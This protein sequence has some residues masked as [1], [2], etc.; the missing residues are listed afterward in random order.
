MNT[1]LRFSLISMVATLVG[2]LFA[3]AAEP[4]GYERKA[5]WSETMLS[6]RAALMAVG[7]TNAATDLRTQ[8]QRR[9]EKDFPVPSRAM[10]T[11]LSGRG[12]KPL[13]WFESDASSDLEREMIDLALREC[14]PDGSRLR[15]SLEQLTQSKVPASNPQWLSLYEKAVQLR[16]RPNQLRSINLPA[17]R[18]AVEDLKAGFGE[19]YPRG[20]E[21]LAQIGTMEREMAELEA[22]T[23]DGKTADPQRATALVAA[24]SKLQREA[25]L[26]NPLLDF[27]RVLVV[28]RQTGEVEEPAGKDG[29]KKKVSRQLGLPQ[30]WQGNCALP[31]GG[32][33][34]QVAVL[35]PVNG[36]GRLTPLFTPEAGRFVGDVDLHFDADR[37]LLS[38]PDS[39]RRWQ[40]WELNIDGTAL[41][42][43][44]PTN[45]TDVDWYD[46]CYL[47]DGRI[48]FAGTAVFQGVPCV[49]GGNKV[50]NMYLLAPRTG[51][52]R[53]V[54]FDQEHNWCP[55]VL[56]NGR[57]LYA[58]WEYTDSPHYFTRLL[59]HM[60]PDGTEQMEFYG[61]NSY[62]PNSIFYARPIPGHPT[63]VV[64][65]ISGHHGV[66]RMGEL[67]VFDPSKGRH[68]NGGAV[69]R[70]PGHGQTVQP[71]VRDG[72][73]EN[74]WP[75]FLHPYP[76]SDKHFLVSAKPNAQS[77]WGIYLVD[78]FDNMVLLH[79]E[80][81]FALLEPVPVRKTPAPPAIQDRVNLARTDATVYL[82]DIYS[83][84][85]LAGVP[86]GAVKSLRIFEYHFAYAGMGGHIN[87]GIDGPWDVHRIIG[88][89]PVNEDGSV[90]FRVPANR[91][92]AVQPLD[93]EGKALQVMRSWFTAMPGENVSC[94]GC[95]EKQNSAPALRPTLASI[96]E[97]VPIQPWHGP[98]RGFSF[99]REVQPVLDQYCVGCHDGKAR[100]DGRTIPDFSAEQPNF[101]LAKKNPRKK[102]G[103]FEF[104]A[105]YVALHPYVRRPGPESDY[106]LQNPGEWHADTSELVQLLQK[107]HHGVKLS[108][109]AWD[110]LITWIDLNVPDHGTW[111]EHRKIPGN[112]AERRRETLARYANRTDDPETYPMPAPERK[113]A[114][115]PTTSET[116]APRP[117][118]IVL[119][120]GWPF[121]GSE[122]RQRQTAA[123]FA[124]QL[125][126][127]ISD[128]LTMELTLIPAGE[129]V[130]GRADGFADEQPQ[131]IVRI[132]K[133]FY[134][135]SFEVSNEEFGAFDPTHDSRVISV[136]NK[137]ISSPGE[138]ANRPRGAVIRVSWQ[139]AMAFCQWLSA[140]TGRRFTLPNEAQWEYACRAG[141]DTAWS[142]GGDAAIF[143]KFANLADE[144]LE[145]LCRGDSPKWIP[146]I[147]NLNDG[148]V[149]VDNVGRYQANA[150]GLKDM[151]GNVAEW[152]LSTCAPYPF[153]K[154]GRDDGSSTGR[155][156][157]R[158]GSFYDRP[159][160]ATSSFRLSY[161][162]WQR[163]FNVGF[164][165]ACE[166]EARV[167]TK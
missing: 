104:D 113:V 61:S 49:G 16:D 106:H 27:D 81:G 53:Q 76:L 116:S 7:K 123:G 85:G 88:T 52:L 35:S 94:V 40:V 136:F 83:G 46:P 11:H 15:E 93:A 107:G 105:A 135:G 67:I 6:A 92:L 89:V 38:M 57:V 146:A 129:F 155:K 165:V 147:T 41:R 59:F 145:R 54:T 126:V 33:S 80:A 101:V 137:D 119:P 150:W 114:P 64:A 65:V 44:S 128:N 125:R 166:A 71:V 138:I 91:P 8:F 72:L 102:V 130:M 69:Q 3:R 103:S 1:I 134:L 142:F 34:N 111:S 30:N 158:G 86:R 79:E 55:T 48:L 124:P 43:I 97:P 26:A 148:S 109:E 45:E 5:S 115:P 122:A 77:D 87:I 132:D 28:R 144:R 141:T 23:A 112:H 98:A 95:H 68:E 108:A 90:N 154:D 118:A 78:T 70:I 17:L 13:Q 143:P 10:K 110:R 22:A 39:R 37:M 120:A 117:P 60:N 139:E 19:R 121:D 62:W 133:P 51:K 24:V 163:V 32:Y 82:Q 160:R 12:R 161:P 140:K 153:R 20:S 96:K 31:T 42:Q 21:W 9:I 58:R 74:S 47:P 66:P 14:G 2:T 100:P 4:A 149:V 56:N 167:A 131:S 63:K 99:P 25:L 73:V 157:V 159:H 156:V 162:T 75:K 50:A 29:K 18:L 151:H 127:P 84:P 152:T 164:R 36:H